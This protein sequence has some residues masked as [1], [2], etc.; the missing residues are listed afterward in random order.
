[1]DELPTKEQLKEKY[2]IAQ[3]DFEILTALTK[4][5]V[6][7]KKYEKLTNL[8]SFFGFQT[9]M[10]SSI[11]G[12]IIAIIFLLPKVQPTINDTV[13][14]WKPVAQYTYDEGMKILDKFQ[15]PQENE[16]L[17]TVAIWPRELKIVKATDEQKEGEF[18]I[19]TELFLVSGSNLPV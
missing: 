11:T 15:K 14:F 17:K 13:E 5:D 6:F 18:P 10:A 4:E 7:E 2:G 1:M 16:D 12:A 9:W 3:D 19:D 8:G